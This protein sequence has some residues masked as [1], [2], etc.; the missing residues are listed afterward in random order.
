MES[1]FYVAQKI[2][3]PNIVPYVYGEEFM[4]KLDFMENLRKNSPQMP[5]SRIFF[6]NYVVHGKRNINKFKLLHSIFEN[7][8]CSEQFK[9]QMLDLFCSIQKVEKALAKF[10]YFYKYKK[11]PIKIKTDMFLNPLQPS[12]KNVMCIFD[13]K[14]SCRY[15]FTINDLIQIIKKSLTHSPNLFSDPTELKNPYTNIPFNKSTLYNIYFFIKKKNF[16]MPDIIQSFFIENFDLENF[17]KNNTY[18][19]REYAIKD[20]INNIQPNE[21]E[22][23]IFNMLKSYVRRKKSIHFD[24][25]KNKL[26]E[27]MRPYLNYY[28]ISIYSLCTE[29]RHAYIH[30]LFYKLKRFF[31]YN[32]NFGRRYLKM[33]AVSSNTPNNPFDPINKIKKRLIIFDDNH[34]SFHEKE[35]SSFLTSHMKAVNENNLPHIMYID[36][37]SDDDNSENNLLS[38]ENESDEEEENILDRSQIIVN[39]IYFADSFNGEESDTDSMS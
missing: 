13:S 11:S 2:M 16:I 37:N 31:D 12:G 3:S 6:Y 29:K 39:Q 23:H 15:L 20:F 30:K 35:N 36:D 22:I 38:E 8:F 10:S 34:I 24:F 18:I 5:L 27:I 4:S 28:F 7:M 9:E 33:Q 19:I 32:P 17:R 14:N 1:F 21:A 25:P 26:L